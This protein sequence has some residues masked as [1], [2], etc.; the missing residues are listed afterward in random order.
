MNSL[1]T[2]ENRK[3]AWLRWI[4]FSEGLILLVAVAGPG[5]RYAV[6][7]R[8]DHGLIA[9]WFV[10]NPSFF[11]ALFVNFVALHLFIGGIWLAAWIVTRAKR[12]P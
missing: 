10:D 12:T 6:G 3:S 9:R 8:S 11:D 4:L 2:S 7:P 1:G 5:Y